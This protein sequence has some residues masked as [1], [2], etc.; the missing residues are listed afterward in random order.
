[1]ASLVSSGQSITRLCVIWLP[2]VALPLAAAIQFHAQP[3]W[4]YM[5]M[6]ASAHFASLKWLSFA[7]SHARKAP[8]GKRLFGYLFIWPGMDVRSFFSAKRHAPGPLSSEWLLAIANLL[9]GISLTV[10]GILSIDRNP[11]VAGGLG[12]AGIVLTMHFG[13][14]HILSILLRTVGV[15]AVVIMDTPIRSASL[16]DFWGNRWNRSFRDLAHR[17]VFKPLLKP[18]GP[19]KAMMAVFVV[20]GL[21]HDLVISLPA[22][23]G[24]G[25]PTIYFLIQGVCV[26]FERSRTGK[27]IGLRRGIPGWLFCALVVLGPVGLLFHAPFLERVIAPML[28]AIGNMVT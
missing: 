26:M 13:I 10:A 4:I 11:I 15:N 23:G 21:V 27:R 12:M 6:F 9:L 28:E 14:F 8:S 22:G 1:M 20:S 17:F 5:W 7:H 16:G 25:L 3:R 18:F 24:Y 2:L 19:A